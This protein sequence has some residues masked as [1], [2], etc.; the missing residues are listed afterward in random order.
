MDNKVIY[1]RIPR[2]GSRTITDSFCIPNNIEYYGGAHVGLWY[3]DGNLYDSV[4]KKIK[5]D[6]KKCYVFSNIRN[7]YRRAISIMHHWR[8]TDKNINFDKF[9]ERLKNNVYNGHPSEK[10]HATPYYKHLTYNN[11]IRVNFIIRLE[12]FED[13]MNFLFEKLNIKKH[14]LPKKNIILKNDIDYRTYYKN[15]KNFDIITN[16]YKDDINF[17]NYKFDDEFYIKK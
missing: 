6:L 16:Y 5:E 2:A 12:N 14:P 7:P 11:K 4:D 17:F 13:D 15:S 10:W 3:K 8:I 1:L 9:C